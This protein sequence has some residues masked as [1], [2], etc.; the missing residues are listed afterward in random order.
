MRPGPDAEPDRILVL[1]TLGAPERRFLGGRRGRQVER[2]EPE[3]VPTSRATVIHAE[4]VDSPQGWLDSLRSGRD[5]AEAEVDAAVRRL[6]DAIR[7]HRLAAADAGARDVT[8]AQALAVRIGYGE[9][10]AVADGRFAD[11]WELP[12][13]RRK[14]KRSM[15]APEER[16]AALVGGRTTPLAGEELVLRARADLDAGRP[17]EAALQARIALEALL[18]ELSGGPADPRPAL[19][20]FR[21]D[22]GEAANAALR[23][24]PSPALQARVEEAVA[25]MEAAL[26]RL[27]L[28]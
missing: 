21:G 5:A 25:R 22:V 2:A 12:G 11:A 10:D 20:E 1:A 3:P 15:A 6:N 7:A 14:T 26:K 9:G 13:E 24:D 19:A 16:F 28:D 18:A 8:A 4:P 27:R 17:R 23:G